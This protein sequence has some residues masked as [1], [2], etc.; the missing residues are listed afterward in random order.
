MNVE[1]LNDVNETLEKWGVS[2]N[3]NNPKEKD[4]VECATKKDAYK[5][6]AILK[7]MK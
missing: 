4:Y 3:G 1:V 6:Q 2:F 5:L 7:G